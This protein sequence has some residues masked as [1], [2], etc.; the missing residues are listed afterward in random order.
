MWRPHLIFLGSRL[1][2]R[3]QQVWPRHENKSRER[4]GSRASRPHCFSRSVTCQW[5]DSFLRYTERRTYMARGG[6]NFLPPPICFRARLMLP[7]VACSERAL[8]MHAHT[9]AHMH[10]T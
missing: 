9:H 8:M 10:M 1:D 6:S 3:W 2:A 5:R 4:R 7:V